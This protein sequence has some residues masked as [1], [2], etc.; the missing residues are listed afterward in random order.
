MIFSERKVNKFPGD[1]FER[2]VL[3]ADFLFKPKVHKK[4]ALRFFFQESLQPY[5]FFRAKSTQG[6]SHMI[7]F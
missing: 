3:K 6:Y 1:F 4:F 5:D 7:F 2:K